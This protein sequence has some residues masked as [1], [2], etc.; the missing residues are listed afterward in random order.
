LA[1]RYSV[2]GETIVVEEGSTIR[3]VLE[4]AGCGNAAQV[5]AGGEVIA[6][7][8]Y[9]RP[10]P[11]SGM[12]TNCTPIEK[13]DSLRERLLDEE[14]LLI[15][16]RFLKRF[17][18]IKSSLEVS[19]NTFLFHNFPLPQDGYKPNQIDLLVVTWGYPDVPPAG[20]HVPA[21]DYPN[22]E[23]IAERLGGHVFYHVPSSLQEHVEELAEQGWSWVCLHFTNWSWRLNPKNLLSGD[24]LY[25]YTENI[26]A[27]LS[28]G[29]R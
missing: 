26:F 6:P 15:T 27:A 29:H 3:E 12:L 16:S 4:E 18:K 19:E 2:D 25:K 24:S 14:A 17:P 7:E 13:G 22:R 5:V 23:R 8:D 11:P 1:K 28:G 9:N 20:V 21:K 10:A